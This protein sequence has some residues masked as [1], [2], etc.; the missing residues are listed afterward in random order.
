MAKVVAEAFL[1]VMHRQKRPPLAV[2]KPFGLATLRRNLSIPRGLGKFT[3]EGF[4]SAGS[5]G[6]R[7]PPVLV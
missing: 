2:Y 3:A 5:A 1:P 4:P 6:A 7:L